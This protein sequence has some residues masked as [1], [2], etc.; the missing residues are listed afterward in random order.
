MELFDVSKLPTAI[1]VTLY[2]Y[3]YID[4]RIWTH[5]QNETDYV[6]SPIENSV[7]ITVN[8]LKFILNKHYTELLNK[9]KTVGSDV[10]HKEVN[11]VY[12]L[13]QITTEMKNLQYI[14]FNLNNDKSYNRIIDVEG[15]KVL[16]FSFKILTATLKLFELYN[17]KELNDVNKILFEIGI[18]TKGK[19]YVRINA[20]ELSDKIDEYL[21]EDDEEDIESGI[22]LDI[23]DILE[24]KIEREDALIL[25]I[26]DY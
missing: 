2:K 9:I 15:S 14:K 16:Q 22:L 18:F 1:D 5:I 10:F 26:T 25:L 6:F 8:Q 12:F 11:S 24:P 7:I 20:K 19:P 3:N 13:H 23:L 17:T 21:G 4:N